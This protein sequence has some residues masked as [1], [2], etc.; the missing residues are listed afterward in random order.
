MLTENAVRYRGRAAAHG[1][2]VMVEPHALAVF[3]ALISD[4]LPIT[5]RSDAPYAAID[6]LYAV[7]PV[8]VISALTRE[9]VLSRY[10]GGKRT[11]LVK[12][13]AL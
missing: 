3:S 4:K 11:A 1:A 12:C 5:A 13:S 9:A 2:G 10:S 8:A 7:C 6:T